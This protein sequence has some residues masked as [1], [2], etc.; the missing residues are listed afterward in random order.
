MRVAAFPKREE[1]EILWANLA[2]RFINMQLQ[3]QSIIYGGYSLIE[4]I[5]QVVIAMELGGLGGHYSLSGL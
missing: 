2:I 3:C 4:L 1:S 5:I